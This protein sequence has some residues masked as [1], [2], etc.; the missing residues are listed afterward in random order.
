MNIDEKIEKYLTE[1][2]K[3]DIIKVVKTENGLEL[4]VKGISSTIGVGDMVNFNDTSNVKKLDFEPGTSADIL[5]I[6]KNGTVQVMSN[7]SKRENVKKIVKIEDIS[8]NKESLSGGK[9]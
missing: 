5:K 1:V 8:F 7:T 3:G 9:F 2:N 4:K 6:N